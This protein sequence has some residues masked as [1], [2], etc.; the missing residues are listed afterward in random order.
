MN[1][2]MIE[3]SLKKLNYWL[4]VHDSYF[5]RKFHLDDGILKSYAV[6]QIIAHE[7][8][9]SYQ[10]LMGKNSITAPND[11][12]ANAY[13]GIFDL[14]VNSSDNDRRNLYFSNSFGLLLERNAQIESYDLAAK[15]AEYNSREDIYDA[16]IRMTHPW[17]TLGY[18]N[19]TCGSVC[20]TYK[21]LK[22]YRDYLTFNHPIQI[23]E[24]ERIRHGFAISD[25][26]RQK[27]LKK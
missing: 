16:F 26:T 20:E 5:D 21:M 18:Q 10:Y 9:H 1:M 7:V 13:K 4:D 8:E 22:M 19:S 6:I 2:E 17:I 24:Q 27:L 12:L 25:K 23:V 14:T 15:I 11:I 3:V